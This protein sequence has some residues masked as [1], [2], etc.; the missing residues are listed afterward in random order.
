MTTRLTLWQMHDLMHAHLHLLSKRTRKKGPYKLTADE[1]TTSQEIVRRALRKN[2]KLARRNRDDLA[3]HFRPL[4]KLKREVS[5]RTLWRH[6]IK[7]VI[8]P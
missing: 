1:I 4:F 8:K 5:N 3:E 7:P 6:I 2:P